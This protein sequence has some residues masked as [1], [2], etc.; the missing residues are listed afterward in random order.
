MG[1]FWMKSC[2]FLTNRAQISLA[3]LVWPGKAKNREL[4]GVANHC[5]L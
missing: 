5:F 2:R 1:F 3:C 4:F